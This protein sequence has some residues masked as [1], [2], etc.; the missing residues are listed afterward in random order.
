MDPKVRKK[1]LRQ[2][3]NGVYVVTSQNG[4]ELAGATIT[5]LT[6]VSFDPPLLAIGVRPGSRISEALQQSRAAVVHLVAPDQK[7]LAKRFFSAPEVDS[8]GDSPTIG[9]CA[10]DATDHGPRLREARGWMFCRVIET[11]DCGGDHNLVVVEVED[12]GQDEG[13]EGLTVQGAG[14]SYGG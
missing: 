3:S 9:G 7:A 4:D 10:F 12:V 2:I 11:L 5:W 8:S 14:W 13:L 1:V 6:Q